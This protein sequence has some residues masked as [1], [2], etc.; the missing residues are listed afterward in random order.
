MCCTM[1]GQF[2]CM[3]FTKSKHMMRIVGCFHYK[4]P[5]KSKAF[6]VLLFWCML[7]DAGLILFAWLWPWKYGAEGSS[8]LAEVSMNTGNKG[9][10]MMQRMAGRQICVCLCLKG[11]E[12]LFS[13]HPAGN[14]EVCLSMERSDSH[15]WLHIKRS[16]Q[17]LS[18]LI[19]LSSSH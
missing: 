19:V 14:T 2:S 4:M 16:G 10:V 6:S 5:Q 9:D 17:L 12:N 13:Q 15:R 11:T 18:C 7:Q 1:T 8:W 3:Q